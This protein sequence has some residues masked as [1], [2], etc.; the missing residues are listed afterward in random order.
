EWCW[1]ERASAYD[2]H[3]VK[4]QDKIIAQERARIVR[5]GFAI[6]HKRIQ[7]LDKI[8]QELIAMASEADKVWIPGQKVFWNG[9]NAELIDTIT[10]NHQLY[11]LIRK[12]LG[13]IASEMGERKQKIE[14]DETGEIE[15][16]SKVLHDL[17]MHA[18]EPFPEAKYALADALMKFEESK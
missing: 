5:S 3:W 6:Q 8:T 18:L 15:Q 11:A 17:C 13:D 7:E 10:F 4:E 16:D 12:Y 2:A 14:I 1:E 9:K